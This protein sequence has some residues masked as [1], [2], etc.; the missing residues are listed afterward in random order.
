[1]IEDRS[2]IEAAVT[3]PPLTPPQDSHQNDQ[4]ERERDKSRQ[5]SLEIQILENSEEQNSMK[6]ATGAVLAATILTQVN[7]QTFQFK[8]NNKTYKFIYVSNV[9]Q[10]FEHK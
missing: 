7:I 2:L 9:L 4:N 3:L 10:F 1:M 5:E 6:M 8:L